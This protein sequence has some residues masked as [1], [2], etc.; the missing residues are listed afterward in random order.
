MNYI[1][2]PSVFYWI[3]VLSGLRVLFGVIGGI[4]IA[5]GLA[6]IIGYIYNK[7]QVI[8]YKN[9]NN[10]MIGP[11]K[12]QA[13]IYEVRYEQYLKICV[14]GAVTCTI[15]GTIMLIVCVLLPN[16]ETS[17]QMLV[18][19]TATFENVDWSVEQIKEIINY[20]VMSLK[21]V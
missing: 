16:K 17:I 12:A 2:D 7:Y 8:Y 1:I 19:R 5:G 6:F 10:K 14:K 9:D 18:S 21:T 4:L 15:I 3:N 11:K 13:V 20:I